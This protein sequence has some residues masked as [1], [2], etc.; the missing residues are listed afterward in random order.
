MWCASRKATTID[1]HT[2]WEILATLETSNAGKLVS[3][4][5]IVSIGNDDVMLLC[6][7]HAEREE[8]WLPRF[9]AFAHTWKEKPAFVEQP[10]APR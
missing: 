3:Y 8:V 1:G 7:A 10:P 2:A 6:Q 9:R 5:T 4:T